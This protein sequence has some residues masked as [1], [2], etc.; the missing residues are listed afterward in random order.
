MDDTLRAAGSFVTALKPLPNLAPPPPPSAATP[1]VHSG[2]SSTTELGRLWPRSAQWTAAVLLG[3][4]L[5]LLGVQ[6]WAGVRGG[7]RPTDQE[8]G[9][10]LDLNQAARAEL[11]QLPGIGPTL[12]DRILAYRKANGPFRRAEDLRK[13]LGVGPATWQRVRD[14]VF[15]ETPTRTEG[16]GPEPVPRTQPGLAAPARQARSK[17]EEAL[18]GQ[19]ID[20][21]RASLQELQRL[22]GIGPKL[23]QR[24]V[25]EREKKRFVSAED[26]RRVP[27]IGPKTLEKLR[28]YVTTGDADKLQ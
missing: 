16:I 19:T 25:D 23:S 24:I 6:L 18:A 9:L 5:T 20:V 3:A 12:A 14:F 10:L 8:P 17:K 15:V 7:A 11:L 4:V 22:P 21:N 13:V 27:G 2:P 1:P 28:P 26:L